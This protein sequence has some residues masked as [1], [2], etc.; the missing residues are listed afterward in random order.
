MVQFEGVGI[1]ISGDRHLACAEA[2]RV[3]VAS[4][5]LWAANSPSLATIN[6]VSF[7]LRAFS[8]P[9]RVIDPARMGKERSTEACVAEG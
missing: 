7:S 3:T 5:H 1:V 4:N 6:F 2:N 8:D 9:T